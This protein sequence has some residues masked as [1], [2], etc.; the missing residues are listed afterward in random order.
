VVT[1]YFR[2]P[3]A[4]VEDSPRPQTRL[5][6]NLA[7][8]GSHF[9]PLTGTSEILGKPNIMFTYKKG[10][11]DTPQ[12]KSSLNKKKNMDPTKEVSKSNPFEVLTAVENDVELCINGG[13]VT[14]VDDD[15]KP[16]EKVASSCDY[17]SEDEVEFV[18]NDM[19]NFLDKNDGYGTRSL[20][21]QWTESYENGDYGYDP[22]DDD[23]YEGQDIPDK[24][25][26]ICDKLDI[27]V[28]GRREK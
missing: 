23:L 27:T 14:L 18:D 15:G 1:S 4:C 24:L 8:Q 6:R 10:Y 2:Q 21:E 19:A 9:G 16:L 25:Q 28:R 12:G 17:D 22:Y 5:Q 26:A 3:L 7:Q 13:K 11:S 20:L